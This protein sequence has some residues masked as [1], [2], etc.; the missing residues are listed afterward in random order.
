MVTKRFLNHLGST[1]HWYN[2][3]G[4]YISM[5]YKMADPGGWGLPMSQPIT[6]IEGNS[7]SSKLLFLQSLNQKDQ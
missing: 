3:T 4:I 5:A 1:K 2:G 7:T 6:N